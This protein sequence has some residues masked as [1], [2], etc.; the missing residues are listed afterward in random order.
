MARVGKIRK[1]SKG[2]ESYSYLMN[3]IAGIGK[4]QPISE[5]VLLNKG[6]TPIGNVQIG[7][8]IYGEDGKL[9]TITNIFPQ[10]IKEVYKVIFSDGT[11]TRCGLEH[12]WHVTTRK[13]RHDSKENNDYRFKVVTL[14]DILEDYKGSN[15]YKY[16]IPVC[17]TI[18]FEEQPIS[19]NPYVL[20]LLL[21]DGGLTENVV[22]F[23]SQEQELINNI[24]LEAKKYSCKIIRK[25]FENHEQIRIVKELNNNEINPFKEELNK[26]KL[27]GKGSREKFIPKNYIYNSENVRID[28]LS[29]I[30]NT[31]GSICKGNSINISTYSKSMMEDIS[32][33]ARSLG[34][35]VTVGEYNRTAENSTKKYNNEIE[36]HIRICG[37]LERLN[38]S[39][40]HTCKLVK[41]KIERIKSIVN[42]EKQDYKEKSICIMVDN[43]NHLYITK[44]Y[45]VTHNTTT[46]CEIGQKKFGV[47]GFLLITLGAEPE[48][49]HIGNLW[50]D[51]VDDWDTLEE[52]IDDIVDNK[53]TDDY[54]DLKMIGMDSIGELF[55]L[56]ETK[57]VEEYNKTVKNV[58]DRVKT[59]N[60]AYG[61][62]Q[63]GNNRVI[64]LVSNLIVKIKRV[65]ISLF[66]IGHT[67]QKNKVDQLTE[68][69]YEQITSDID[70]K[71]YN[72]IKDRVNIVMCAYMERE[73]TDLQTRKDAFSK[74]EKQ[75]GTIANEK[76]VVSFR[77]ESYAIDLKCHLKHIIAKCELDSNIIIN[78]LEEA[79]GKQINDFG[80]ESTTK[81]EIIKERKK[82]IEDKPKELSE[83]EK[84]IIVEEIKNNLAN[85]SMEDLQSIMN[86]YKF[87]NF[88]DVSV[89]P[90]EALEQI[91]LLIK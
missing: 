48:P 51:V 86:T 6:W 14:K 82:D 41:R 65:G 61:G 37:D 33:L 58:A 32:E 17:S 39:N 73:L 22:T 5:P 79:I 3:G 80:G 29:G 56:A 52:H 89:I 91:K 12:L 81:D 71:Y 36:W 50:N 70:N 10:G 88:N 75:I 74:K 83:D 19:I 84:Q 34:F 43:P 77:D 4:E 8:K 45:I 11:F 60:G 2:I 90:T 23:T 35:I 53:N 87:S 63:K 24:E 21:G 15:Y 68:I 64:D 46:V 13:Q 16:S 69:E 67:K 72:A 26:L 18:N 28:V 76:R 62:F 57:V 66:F 59:I 42:I 49:D 20:G 54:K 78:S 85:I 31:D 9:H 55:R 47:D 30:V 44:D 7:D 27:I 38:L 1:V 25:Q 40:K